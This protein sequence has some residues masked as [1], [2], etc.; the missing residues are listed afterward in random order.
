[1]L[2]FVVSELGHDALPPVDVDDDPVVIGSGPEARI[3]ITAVAARPAHVRI[4]QHR[5]TALA[6]LVIDGTQR[7]AGEAGELT[8]AAT[9]ELDRYR[10]QVSPSPPGAVAATPQRTESLAREL[11]RSLLGSGSAPFFEIERGPTIGAKRILAPPESSVVIGR[12]DEATWVILDPDLSRAHAEVRRG[13][14]GITICDLQSKNGTRVDGAITDTPVG[15]RH[16]AI[17]ELGKVVLRF[18]DPA[19][20]HLRAEAATPTDTVAPPMPVAPVA[21]VTPAAA[22]APRPSPWPFMIAA[23][24]AAL[25]VVG[26]VWILGS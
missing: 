22:V 9:F 10:V 24:I 2:R 26:L 6:R 1:M 5:W 16:G 17:V 13:W 15:L 19:E 20:S 14:D 8:E 11:V 4:A 18:R 25:A 21:P 23:T 3:R 12:G 7:E